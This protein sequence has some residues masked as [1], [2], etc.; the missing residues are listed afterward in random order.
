MTS[1]NVGPGPD[2]N[3]AS[4]GSYCDYGRTWAAGSMEQISEFHADVNKLTREEGNITDGP[5][6][7]HYNY[8]LQGS[9]RHTMCV[10]SYAPAAAEIKKK[11][12]VCTH[13]TILA[14]A[15]FQTISHGS[16][17]KY[18]TN[19]IIINVRTLLVRFWFGL[20]DEYMLYIPMPI[21]ARIYE[22]YIFVFSKTNER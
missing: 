7:D 13:N 11:V 8:I 22:N 12:R 1:K 5:G 3:I 14:V 15:G 2:T 9:R 17:Q 16:S 20:C 19:Y 21:C 10:S 4:K 6:R 18:R